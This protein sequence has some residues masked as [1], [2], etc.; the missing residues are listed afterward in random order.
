MSKLS[1]G[2]A[3][4]KGIEYF[5]ELFFFYGVLFGLV[6]YEMYKGIE[7][8]TKHKETVYRVENSL[9]DNLYKL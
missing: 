9:K 6:A 1:K 2:A 3:L 8:S 7:D 5:T 4:N